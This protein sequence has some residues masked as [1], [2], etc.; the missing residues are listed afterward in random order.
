MNES[1]L[2]M[3]C[4]GSNNVADPEA[5]QS[6]PPIQFILNSIRGTFLI[7]C[8]MVTLRVVAAGARVGLFKFRM[9]CQRVFPSGGVDVSSD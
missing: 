8:N 7:L 4:G 2:S 6:N 9:P 3:E 1:D 5:I